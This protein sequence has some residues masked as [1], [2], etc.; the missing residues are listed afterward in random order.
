VK[1]PSEFI[2]TIKNT[3]GAE[4]EAWVLT[5]PDLIADVSHRWGLTDIRPVPGLS[6]NFVAIVG[7][8]AESSFSRHWLQ[9]QPA[10]A[11]TLQSTYVLKLGVPNRELT[12]E[13]AALRF[14]AACWMQMRKRGCFFW[15]DFSPAG[16]FPC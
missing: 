11:E 10:P 5:L 9:S 4:G 1:L 3:F 13:I 8:N 12:S 2:Q 16:C 6:Y 14:Y 7:L 15:R